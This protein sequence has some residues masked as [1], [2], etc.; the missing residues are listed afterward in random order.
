[1]LKIMEGYTDNNYKAILSI[2]VMRML[3]STYNTEFFNG[4]LAMPRFNI[5]NSLSKVGN[6][7]YDYI[8]QN[9]SNITIEISGRFN[10]T[11]YQLLSILI[12]EMIHYYLSVHGI[13]SSNHGKEFMEIANVLNMTNEFHVTKKIDISEYERV[14]KKSILE[15]F[16]GL[17]NNK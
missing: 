4:E 9:D 11:M 6:F 12:H 13:N 1:M 2:D 17:F 5:T 8:G 15:K 16:L 10:Y 7:K 14:E 3:F